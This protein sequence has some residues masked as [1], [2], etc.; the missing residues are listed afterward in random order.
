ML[1]I[2]NKSV[3]LLVLFLLVQ[4]SAVYAQND[5]LKVGLNDQLIQVDA[6]NDGQK[7][8]VLIED[9]TFTYKVEISKLENKSLEEQLKNLTSV[10]KKKKKPY[11]SS[12]F[13]CSYVKARR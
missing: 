13:N 11:S 7:I 3:S 2:M 8:T 1:K 12:W 6:P 9:S 4:M 10:S 5:T